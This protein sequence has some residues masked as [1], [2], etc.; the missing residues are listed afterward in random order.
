MPA[1]LYSLSRV[2]DD[3]ADD[4]RALLAR[5]EIDYYETTAGNWGISAP[6]IWLR[7]DSQLEPARALIEAYE[8]ER[9]ARVRAEYAQLKKEG[10]NR[11]VHD[12]MRENP[13]RFVAYVA[14]IAAIV[15]FSVMPFL[16][17]G[18]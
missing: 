17:I 5:N 15:Y 7:E 18:K 1:R 16:D 2:P 6:A 12:V 14:L 11:T 8:A 3:E 13:G 10:R 9:V 4:I